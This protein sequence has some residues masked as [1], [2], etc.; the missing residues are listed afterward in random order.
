MVK[1]MDYPNRMDRRLLNSLH[2]KTGIR[3]Y[4]PQAKSSRRFAGC[5]VGKPNVFV[6]FRV[7]GNV[8]PVIGFSDPT[9]GCERSYHF[10]EVSR[11]HY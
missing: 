8:V 11:F 5:K 1:Q 10:S 9:M 4:S 3:E 6:K 2:C 7:V